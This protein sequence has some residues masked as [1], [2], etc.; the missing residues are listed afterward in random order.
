MSFWRMLNLRAHAVC[1]GC[2]VH[3]AS[4]PV[5]R[6]STISYTHFLTHFSAHSNNSFPDTA[7]NKRS[8]PNKAE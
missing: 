5:E 2:H 1:A 7:P 4:E 8:S 3:L 6:A